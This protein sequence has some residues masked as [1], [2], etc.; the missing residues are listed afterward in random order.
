V[1]RG[2]FAAAHAVETAVLAI[3][4]V[5]VSGARAS[6]DFLR[7]I[8]P[9]FVGG[10]PAIRETCQRLVVSRPSRRFAKRPSVLA[11]PDAL[12]A[13]LDLVRAALPQ[14][15][16]PLQEAAGQPQLAGVSSDPG[17]RRRLL[18]TYRAVQQLEPWVRWSDET[19][20]SFLALDLA[21]LKTSARGALAAAQLLGPRYSAVLEGGAAR[22]EGGGGLGPPFDVAPL[23]VTTAFAHLDVETQHVGI[24][25]GWDASTVFQV[26]WQPLLVMTRSATS[27]VAPAYRDGF[28]TSESFRFARASTTTETAIVGRAGAT[29]IDLSP[30]RNP[31]GD[32]N[33]SFATADNGIAEWALVFD[34]GLDFRWYDRDVWIEHLVAQSADPLVDVYLGLRHDQRF[35][36]AGDLSEFDDPT[37]RLVFSFFVSPFRVTDRRSGTIGHTW[38]TFGGGFEFEGARRGPSRLPSGFRVVLAGR[39]D[40]LRAWSA[41]K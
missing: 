40:L 13:C 2:K 28:T 39:L 26:G 21:S 22:A 24:G 29:R 6:A 18:A 17:Q 10:T 37:G 11:S 1:R 14:P 23:G 31:G 41:G 25:A 33:Q 5:A 19:Q 36:R 16:P 7:R 32:P 35:H 12:A 15:A 27:T 20:G 8:D 9:L 4:L 3:V 34:A 30:I 38:L